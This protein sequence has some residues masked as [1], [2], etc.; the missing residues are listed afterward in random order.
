MERVKYF[1][2]CVLLMP[3]TGMAQQELLS[4]KARAGDGI[5]TFLKR[6]QLSDQ[7]VLLTLS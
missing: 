2:I 1:W 7:N 5:Y 6:Y 4:A 3:L